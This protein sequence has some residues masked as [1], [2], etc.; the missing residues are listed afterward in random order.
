LANAANPNPAAANR[1]ASG[2]A[3]KPPTTTTRPATTRTEV[4]VAPA[5]FD[6]H[7]GP[8]TPRVAV[9]RHLEWLE[10]ALAAARAEESWRRGRLNK[11]RKSNVGKRETR[12]AEVVAEI[13][14]LSALV[15][16]LRDL[17][18]RAAS[19]ATAPRPSGS[20]RTSAGPASRSRR[21]T[22]NGAG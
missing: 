16:G 20:R 9:S 11:A 7:V 3:R 21:T 12:L 2:P 13:A 14:E 4:I 6:T 18:R 5:A 10:Y 8:M 1:V 15:I 22:D 17:Q 19:K